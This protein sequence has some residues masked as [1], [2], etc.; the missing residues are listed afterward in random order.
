MVFCNKS[1]RAVDPQQECDDF[2]LY[3]KIQARKAPR[4]AKA[5]QNIEGDNIFGMSNN[6]A[7]RPGRL[8]ETV[9][10]PKMVIASE[11]AKAPESATVL[12]WP[13]DWQLSE[14][15]RLKG[16]QNWTPWFIRWRAAINSIGYTD[17]TVLTLLDEA[18]LGHLLL[19]NIADGPAELVKGL[20]RGTHMF[21]RLRSKFEDKFPDLVGFEETHM[22]CWTMLLGLQYHCDSCPLEYISNFNWLYYRSKVLV[23]DRTLCDMFL[24]GVAMCNPSDIVLEWKEEQTS[25]LY[26]GEPINLSQIQDSF[27]R[28]LGAVLS[29]DEGRG[30]ERGQE[31][32]ISAEWK[33]QESQDGYK[34]SFYK[35]GH[36]CGSSPVRFGNLRGQH[37]SLRP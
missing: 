29:K 22:F 5:K 7:G 32:I 15:Y 11:S 31:R 14:E 33:Q 25:A 28:L 3:Q 34:C 20:T 6:I 26:N 27:A 18:K 8:P 2:E 12:H 30:K 37:D 24:K 21:A 1:V 36:S 23:S 10:E 16:R 13:F 17:D 35:K 4:R 9:P 19:N